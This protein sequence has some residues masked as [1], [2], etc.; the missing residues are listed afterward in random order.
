M[1]PADAME[2]E[3]V[4]IARSY[5]L[6]FERRLTQ[7]KN[8]KCC[9]LGNFWFAQHSLIFAMLIARYSRAIHLTSPISESVQKEAG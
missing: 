9:G 5:W 4:K 6:P 1:S 2:R 3:L 7:A 8:W